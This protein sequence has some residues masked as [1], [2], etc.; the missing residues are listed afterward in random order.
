MAASAFIK[1]SFTLPGLAALYGWSGWT[2]GGSVSVTG[3]LV[4]DMNGDGLDD[5]ALHFW[6]APGQFGEVVTGPTPNRLVT[7]LAQ[8]D[9]SFID[10]TA[11]LFGTTQPVV[12]SGNSR[13]ADLGDVNRDGRLD[14]LYVLSR[15]DG[16][17]SNDFDHMA[18]TSAVV[19]SQAGGGY[20]VVPVGNPDWYHAGRIYESDGEMHVAAQGFSPGKS[21][22]A[23]GSVTLELAE[24]YEWRSDGSGFQLDGTIPARASTFLVLP[25]DVPGGPASSVFSIGSLAGG[26]FVPVLAQ[27][28]GDGQW[29]ISDHAV[30]FPERQTVPFVWWNL[31]RG[32]TSLAMVDGIPIVSLVFAESSL[33]HPGPS[34]DAVVAVQAWGN[35]IPAP[36]SDGYYYEGDGDPFR[37]LLFYRIEDGELVEA[38]IRITGERIFENYNNFEARDLN[39]DGLVDIVTYPFLS[40]TQPRVY[41]N[42]GNLEFRLLE[43]SLLPAGPQWGGVDWPNG[44]AKFLDANG[45]GVLD[46]L[47]RPTNANIRWGVESFTNWELHIGTTNRFADFDTTS[48][49]LGDRRGGSLLATWGGNDFVSDLNAASGSTRIDGGAGRDTAVYSGVRAGYNVTHDSSSDGWTVKG[50]GGISDSLTRFERVTFADGSLALDLD[51]PAGSVVRTIGAVFGAATVRERPD[52]VGIG[53]D[54]LDSGMSEAAL[55]ELALQARFGSASNDEVV[56]LLYS[57]LVGSAPSGGELAH[58]VGMLEGGMSRADLGLLAAYTGLNAINIDL[59]GLQSQGV[60]YT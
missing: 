27:L 29:T 51:G 4:T 6:Q 2:A 19:L 1:S 43:P 53:L 7:Y 25:P 22:I 12:L 38:G 58:Y 15:E 46:L 35:A 59:V 3:A 33:L 26:G 10:A 24:T 60:A 34:F 57:N 56:T 45:D 14:W 18:S 44:E 11:S 28:G 8:P 54:L 49:I 39:S 37:K 9:G 13:K 48:I 17:N 21:L 52:Y 55:M 23:E 20:S 31:N 36:R 30:P 5:I 47:Y 32:D 41:L 40:P 16:R 50:L 42:L